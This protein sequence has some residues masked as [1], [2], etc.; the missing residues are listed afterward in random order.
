MRENTYVDSMSLWLTFRRQIPCLCR[1]TRHY[2]HCT[3]N[4][5]WLRWLHC[6][7][8]DP[9][10]ARRGAE[11]SQ[12]RT[13]RRTPQDMHEGIVL[14]RCPQ[15]KQ[16]PNRTHHQGGRRNIRF[17]V[18]RH[19]LGVRKGIERLWPANEINRMLMYGYNDNFIA[20]HTIKASTPLRCGPQIAAEWP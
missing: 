14:P 12:S 9:Q 17:D 10:S 4:C 13:S 18:H 20:L 6:A 15:Y 7:T 19:V 11:R 16:V 5:D 8:L 2:I 3:L 1:F